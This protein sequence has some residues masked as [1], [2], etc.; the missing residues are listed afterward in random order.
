MY[1][2]SLNVL[3]RG[4]SRIWKMG[5]HLY[6]CKIL[7][8]LVVFSL[9][10]SQ[11][12]LISRFLNMIDCSHKFGAVKQITSFVY[13]HPTGENDFITY[14]IQKRMYAPQRGCDMPMD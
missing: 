14:T 6:F 8:Y 11:T 3:S 2:I 4:G 1:Y 12:R 10:L 7:D 13:C 9:T 5:V